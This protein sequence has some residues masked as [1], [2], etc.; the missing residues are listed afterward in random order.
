MFSCC[1]S[2]ISVSVLVA[3]S[4]VFAATNRLGITD[5]EENCCRV[6]LVGLHGSMS[7]PR[8]RELC[9]TYGHVLDVE[10]PLAPNVIQYVSHQPVEWRNTHIVALS[11]FHHHGTTPHHTTP[12]DRH[13]AT[14]HHT[15][16]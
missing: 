4:L 15:T 6:L 16:P 13:D 3:V 12:H 2:F 8:I 7:E 1:V 11:N 5:S 14:P 10:L 9:T